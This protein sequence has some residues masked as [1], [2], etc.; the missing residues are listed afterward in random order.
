MKEAPKFD[1]ANCV[2]GV[3]PKEGQT[4]PRWVF[5]TTT[6]VAPWGEAPSSAYG[7][8]LV[9]N[10]PADSQESWQIVLKGPRRDTA[11]T[12]ANEAKDNA[13]NIKAT[14]QYTQK[15][16]PSFASF[17]GFPSTPGFGFGTSDFGTTPGGAFPAGTATPPAPG[18]APTAAQGPGQ[19][20]QAPTMPWYFWLLIP[21]G[22]MGLSLVRHTILEPLPGKRADG[23][24]ALIRRHNAARL[25]RS[26][27]AETSGP[28][29]A[30]SG[31]L[32]STGLRIRSLARRVVSGG[33]KR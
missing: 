12:P 30:L 9:G 5:D 24:V 14:I 13:G 17:E 18:T 31:A 8:M 20:Q 21:T 26:L 25:G 4:P 28:L 6:L 29:L 7:V 32:R 1:A 33:K 22:L 27:T 10:K 15:A 11:E 19:G 3:P 2:D 23:V 16:A